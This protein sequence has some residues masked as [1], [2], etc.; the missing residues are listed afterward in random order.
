MRASYFAAAALAVTFS[1]P[2]LSQSAAV[3][4][5]AFVKSAAMSDMY[6]IQAS[7]LAQTRATSADV[8]T[9]ASQ[10]ITDHTKTSDQMKAMV[11]GK[12]GMQIPTS[13]DQ[14]HATMLRNLRSASGANF[15]HLYVQQQVQAHNQAVTLF[16]NEAQDGRDA[17]LKGFAGQTLPTLQQHLASAQQLSK[18]GA[19][20]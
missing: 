3:R 7:Q 16:T 5:A 10:M 20:P 9:F 14:Q 4:D 13:L 1:L 12:S 2:A 8:K 11:S 17:D 6:E 18:G 19:A 15:D